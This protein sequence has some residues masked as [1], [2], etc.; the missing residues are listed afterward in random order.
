MHKRIIERGLISQ[1]ESEICNTLI[2][3]K[4]QADNKLLINNNILNNESY[5][6]KAIFK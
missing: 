5:F 2:Q 3:I 4:A 1:R 6:D